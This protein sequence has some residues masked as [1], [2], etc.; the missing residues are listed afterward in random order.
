MTSTYLLLFFLGRFFCSI[1]LETWTK[2]RISFFNLS[3]FLN[4]HLCSSVRLVGH[5]FLK[6]LEVSLPCSY[7]A[8]RS[9]TSLWPG[10]S[11]GRSVCHNFLKG[12]EVSPPCSYRSTCYKE[13]KGRV[14]ELYGILIVKKIEI[15]DWILFGWI[16]QKLT[17]AELN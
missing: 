6:G 5:N 7:L 15:V 14:L 11:I 16:C 12:R 3:S 13:R 4:S 8:I 17:T 9:E 10:L 2:P 1:F